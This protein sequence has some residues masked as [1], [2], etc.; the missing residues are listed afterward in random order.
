ME[1]CI[2]EHYPIAEKTSNHCGL[3]LLDREVEIPAVA[4]SSRSKRNKK[5]ENGNDRC[6]NYGETGHSTRNC[7][8]KNPNKLNDETVGEIEELREERLVAVWTTRVVL[9]DAVLGESDVLVVKDTRSMIVR[10]EFQSTLSP[11][12]ITQIY[13]KSSVKLKRSL[14]NSSMGGRSPQGPNVEPRLT[15]EKPDWLL[16]QF[17]TFTVSN[18]ISSSVHNRT[19]ML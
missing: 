5:T 17:T 7:K 1:L 9:L 11:T 15:W 12:S 8:K 3:Q 2:N 19:S 13:W 6:Y 10:A 16:V 18:R 4:G 14:W